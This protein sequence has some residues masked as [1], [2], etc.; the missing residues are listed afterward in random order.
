M[1]RKLK[2]LG[3]AFLLLLATGA[4]AGAF[5]DLW[6]DPQQPGWG[7]NVVQQG[8]VAFVTLFAYDVDGRPVWY[9]ASDARVTAYGN[10]GLPLFNGAL[11]RARGSWHGGPFD[12]AAFQPVR[13]GTIDLELRGRSSMRV[14][15]AADGV[16]VVRDVVRQTWQQELVAANYVGQFLLRVTRPGGQPIGGRDFGADILVHFDGD[17]GFMRAD[18]HG[19]GRCEYRGPYEQSGK[20]LAFTGTF[21]CDSGD[22][23]AGTFEMRDIEVT[24]NGLTGLLRTWSDGVN[25]HGRLGAVRR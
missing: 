5:T 13:V 25:Q 6:Y 2:L 4:R 18:L 15:Y 20:V 14:H 10:G 23:R 8:E 22:A 17:E 1:S 21:T 16:R 24:D 3:A 12:P 19:G 7:L 9:F 11:Y